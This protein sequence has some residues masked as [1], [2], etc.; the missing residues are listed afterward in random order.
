MRR[1]DTVPS[2]LHSERK[3]AHCSRSN[4]VCWCFCVWRKNL[5]IGILKL[6]GSSRGRTGAWDQAN[7]L[8]CVS[9]QGATQHV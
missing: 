1:R 8:G 7:R 6:L 2:L 5:R 4:L 3:S 9:V